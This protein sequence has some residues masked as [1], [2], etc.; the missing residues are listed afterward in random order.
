MEFHELSEHTSRS[1]RADVV[2]PELVDHHAAA[3]A[4]QS[5]ADAAVQHGDYQTA[6]ELREVAE[7]DAWDAGDVS[8]LHGADAVELAAAAEYQQE[9]AEVETTQAEF[10]RNGDYQSAKEAADLAA[11]HIHEADFLAGGDNHAGQ[12][13]LESSNMD[14]AVWHEQMADDMLEMASFHVEQGNLDAAEVSL[15]EANNHLDQADHYGDLGEHDGPFAQTDMA[16]QSEPF[17]LDSLDSTTTDDSTSSDT[18]STSTSMDDGGD[19]D[20]GLSDD[21]SA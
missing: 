13:E 8:H 6:A 18:W 4:A 3:A 19:M 20:S 17:E 14:W 1:N 12:A 2:E 16:S 21:F 10:A 7:Q 5:A 11:E 9:A 15:N